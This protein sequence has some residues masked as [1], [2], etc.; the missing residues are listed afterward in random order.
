MTIKRLP[1]DGNKWIMTDRGTDFFV[2]TESLTTAHK[3]IRFPRDCKEFAIIVNSGTLYFRGTS[4]GTLVPL[5]AS[6]VVDNGDGT[7]T[8]T[9]GEDHGFTVTDPCEIEGTT[10]YDGTAYTVLAGSATDQLVITATYVAE[11]PTTAAYAV[12]YRDGSTTT[13]TGPL[14]IVKEAGAVCLT[15]WAATTAEITI[16]AWR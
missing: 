16:Y 12:G 13:G 14:P 1:Y 2:S 11:T 4:P 3:N 8:I 6:A 10:N 9:T 7:V 5:A 15:V